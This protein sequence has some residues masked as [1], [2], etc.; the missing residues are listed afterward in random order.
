[1]GKITINDI[2]KKKED[3]QKITMLTAYD[4]PFAKI[5][6]EAG[7]DGILVGDSLAMVVQGLENTLPVTMDEMIYHTKIVSRATENAMV[8]GD[9]PFMSYQKSVEDAIWNAGRFIKEG[10]AQAVKIE[11]GFE[12]ADR[13]DAIV[14]SE[15]PVMA[16]IGLTPQAIHRIGGYKVQG[17]TDESKKILMEQALRLEEAGAFSLVL[18]AVP[19]ELAEEI[20]SRLYIPTIGIGAGPGCDGQIL[21]LHDVIGLFDRFVPKFVKKYANLKDDALKAVKQYI[22][23]VKKGVF[24]SEKESFK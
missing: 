8:I 20:T 23:E 5:V 2:I 21:V 4:Y 9:M 18:E 15:I 6:D 11:G 14:K 1:M 7:I 12:V 22:S 17:K 19:A 13:V 24:P 3:G 16:H 10:R